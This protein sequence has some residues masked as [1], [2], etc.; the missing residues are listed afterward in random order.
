V[1]LSDEYELAF[2]NDLPWENFSIKWPES[3]ICDDEDCS[4][5]ALYDYLL[6]LVEEPQKLWH[7]KHQLELHS[8]FRL[9][10]FNNF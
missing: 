7:M 9:L 4:R 5:S 10:G 8:C 1:I 2:M 6:S 3:R